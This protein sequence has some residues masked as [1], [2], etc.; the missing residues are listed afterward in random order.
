MLMVSVYA[1]RRMNSAMRSYYEEHAHALS[2]N[3]A[4][5]KE[6]AQTMIDRLQQDVVSHNLNPGRY[7]FKALQQGLSEHQ[8]W[9]EG[10]RG[11]QPL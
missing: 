4:R 8:F 2:K 1:S 9:K 5:I 10:D 6:S 11:T 7:S 3:R